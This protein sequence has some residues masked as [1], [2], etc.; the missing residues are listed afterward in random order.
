[1]A[2]SPH[3]NGVTEVIVK[4]VKGI[5]DSLTQA[6]RTTVLHLN[7][8][9]TLMKEVASLANERPIGLKPNLQTDPQFLSPN[10]L[11]LGRCSD[12]MNAGPFQNKSDYENDPDSDRTRY[13]LIQKITNQF[14]TTWQK[15]YFP[16]LLTRQKW[17]HEERNLCVGD[18]CMMKDFNSL[19]GEWKICRVGKVFPDVH[20]KVR[21]VMVYVPPP[22]LSASR[23]YPKKVVMNELRRHV[24]N[25]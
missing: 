20:G 1:M 24:S 17:H 9:F 11:L 8:L 23:T 14:W 18:V 12:R 22:S 25:L 19:R 3:Q 7:E 2:A 6:I 13:L 15:V 16:T 10:S 21:N 5:I 4:M